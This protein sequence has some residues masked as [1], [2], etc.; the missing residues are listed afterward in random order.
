MN[1]L[2]LFAGAGGGLLGTRLLGWRTV[3]YVEW[4]D[5]CQRVIRQRIIDGILDSAPIFGDIRTFISEGYAASYTGM[6]D[7]ITGGFPCQAH[8]SASHGKRTARD[9]WPEMLKVVCIIRPTYVFAENVSRTA[10]AT[11]A[12]DLQ[13]IGYCTRQTALSAANLGADHI[14]ERYWLLAHA[15]SNGKLRRTLDAEVGVMP[16]FCSSI[17]EAYSSKSGVDDGMAY[18]VDRLKAIGNGQVPIVAATAWNL[19]N[20]F[21]E[22]AFS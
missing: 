21:R 11:A 4:D 16:K 20:Q 7:V 1:E 17:W 10:I 3:G 13:Q 2:A 12:R 19:L 5:Y 9:W 6:V 22:Q 8:S 14:R 15:N 18:R